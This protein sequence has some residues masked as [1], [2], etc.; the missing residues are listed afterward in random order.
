MCL[1]R[2]TAPKRPIWPIEDRNTTGTTSQHSISFCYESPTSSAQGRRIIAFGNT[3]AYCFLL[4][5][6][7]GTWR[8]QKKEELFSSDVVW[9][10]FGQFT[11][12]YFRIITSFYTSAL[13][14]HCRFVFLTGPFHR[15]T[16]WQT[17]FHLCR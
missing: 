9:W 10:R 2:V 7:C 6:K 5:Y 4:L 14:V 3:I 1:E 15:Q 11:H 17:K 13:Q 12:H 16:P 8:L